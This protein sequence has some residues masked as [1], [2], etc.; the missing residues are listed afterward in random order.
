M[1]GRIYK[2]ATQC[3]GKNRYDNK[4]D[5]KRAAKHAERRGCGRLSVYHCE[6]CGRFH[7]GHKPKHAYNWNLS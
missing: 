2:P 3:D 7:L 5:A 1:T 4:A 6:H